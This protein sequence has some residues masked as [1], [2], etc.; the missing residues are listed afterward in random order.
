MKFKPIE[1]NQLFFGQ[2]HYCISFFLKN[3][4]V[5]R[6]LDPIK[7]LKLYIIAMHGRRRGIFDKN[8]RR[9]TA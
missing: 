1:R 5:L 2:Y 3:V 7:V 6:V 9:R 8:N 4:N